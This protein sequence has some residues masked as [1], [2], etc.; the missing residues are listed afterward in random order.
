VQI[1]TVAERAKNARA[2]IRNFVKEIKEEGKKK[3]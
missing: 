2:A 1:G 3:K